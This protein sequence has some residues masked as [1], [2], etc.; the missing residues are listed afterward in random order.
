[1][2]N[3]HWNSHEFLLGKKVYEKMKKS[4]AL[5]VG[6]GALGCEYLKILSK[7]GI[8]TNKPETL[9]VSTLFGN[10]TVFNHDDDVSLLMRSDVVELLLFELLSELS[11]FEHDCNIKNVILKK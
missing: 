5:L 2:E 9:T 10:W 11:L 4:K 1:M 7:S 8:C 6:S 3:Q